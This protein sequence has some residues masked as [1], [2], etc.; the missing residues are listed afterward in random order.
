MCTCMGEASLCGFGLWKAGR[1]L[2]RC[3]LYDLLHVL[4]S[5]DAGF[6]P[7]V[8]FFLSNLLFCLGMDEQSAA[9]ASCSRTW[10]SRAVFLCIFAGIDVA[11]GLVPLANLDDAAL[12]HLL[13]LS[14]L[15]AFLSL[16]YIVT[17]S[18][19]CSSFPRGTI[20]NIL[21]VKWRRS[22]LQFFITII[23]EGNPPYTNQYQSH[24]MMEECQQY[25]VH[26][27]SSKLKKQCTWFTLLKKL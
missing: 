17:L 8:W 26:D 21:L 24:G 9:C 20:C 10:E 16:E 1:F 4:V 13:F 5:T 12:Q 23:K 2:H 18:H 3:F 25:N 15:Y 27:L 19:H 14:L 7:P 6:V 11:F 22:M